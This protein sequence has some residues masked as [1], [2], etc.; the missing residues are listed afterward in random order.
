MNLYPLIHLSAFFIYLILALFALDKDSKSLLNRVFTIFALCL[1]IWS[2]ST[3]FIHS[4]EVSK[5]TALFFTKLSS[6]GWC[7]FSSIFLWWSIVYADRKEILR[8]RLFQWL[9]IG[10]TIFYICRQWGNNPAINDLAIKDFGWYALYSKDIFHHLYTVYYIVSMFLG[11]YFIYQK[12]KESK[13]LVV[14]RTS[15][16]IIFFGIIGVVFGTISDVI[17]PRMFRDCNFPDLGDLSGILFMAAIY[18]AIL[19]YKFFTISPARAANN[20]ISVMN[21]SLLLLDENGRIVNVNSAAERL[22]EY[23]EDELIGKSP[24]I[25][26]YDKNIFNIILSKIYAEG[27]FVNYEIHIKSKNNKVIPVIFSGNVLLEKYGAIDGVVYIFKD[28]S[29]IKQAEKEKEQLLKQQLFQTQKMAAIGTLAGSVAHEINNPLS[30]IVNNAQL[31]HNFIYQKNDPSLNELKLYL[32]AIEESACRCVKISKSLLG[33]SRASVGNTEKLSL[34]S[35]IDNV[36]NI[37]KK[38]ITLCE[39]SVVKNLESNL[40]LV[41]ADGQ[42][43]QQVIFNLINNAKWAIEKKDTDEKRVITIK[44]ENKIQD[45]Q[46]VISISDTGVGISKENLNRIFESFFTTKNV[47][48]GTGLGLFITEKIVKEHNG[49]VE[50]ESEL[51]KFTTFRVKLPAIG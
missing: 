9:I 25:I 45:K 38:D 41:S 43:L 15:R 7:S 46:V 23:K 37:I 5:D 34:N 50:V 22:L 1:G 11:F 51:G 48:E 47:G 24:E 33:F 29:A 49:S 26:F 2:F 20:I 17:L 14:K 40:N 27:I 12:G 21:D 4:K 18:Y 32:T 3:I 44:T 19:K 39:I 13:R 35:L 10:I 16:I 36:L 42:L 31:V 30:G 6:F 28:I 8:N